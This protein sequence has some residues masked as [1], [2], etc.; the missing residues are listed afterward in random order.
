MRFDAGH[1]WDSPNA[2][3]D[4][5]DAPAPPPNPQPIGNMR[6]LTRF[7]INPFTARGISLDELTAFA[8]DHLERMV[9]NNPGGILDTRIA[10]TSAALDVLFA[11]AGSDAIKAGVR[12]ARKAA[13]NAFRDALLNH[14]RRI[15]GALETIYGVDSQE[16]MEAFP[17][18]RSIYSQCTDDSMTFNLSPMTTVVAANAAALPP[19]HRHP[20]RRSRPQLDRPACRE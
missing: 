12:R 1:F 14:A 15:Q 6:N 5:E 8:S 4:A 16:V 9:A 2:F 3:Y 18:G 20:R 13:K 7:L 17:F 11:M 19:C 10:A